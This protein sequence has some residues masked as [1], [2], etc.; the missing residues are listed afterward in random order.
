MI[1]P[2]KG[3]HARRVI[4]AAGNLE[5]TRRYFW[6]KGKTGVFPVDQA[7]GIEQDGPITPGAVQMMVRMGIVG[8]F[9]QGAA[10]L[11]QIGGVTVGREKLRLVV[12]AEGE[13]VRQA[14]VAGVV[15]ASWSE[16]DA[17][18]AEG[19][20]KGKTR[21]YT[22]ADG[23]FVP[24]VTQTEKD[25]RR[26]AQAV[27]RQ[28]RSAAGVGNTREL[29]AARA[30]TREKSREMKLGLFYDQEKRRRHVFVTEKPCE[31]FGPLLKIFAG[32]VG[33]ER[34]DQTISLSDG[35]KWIYGQVCAFLLTL[36]AILLDFYH[37][38]QH[39]HAAATECFGQG[40]A[41]A[42][43]WAK[44]RL[45]EIK[46]LG[47]SAVLAAIEAL[48]KK[49]RAPRK[50]ES[51]RLL[52]EYIASRLDMLDYR[53]A[54]A[55]G[56]DIGS[57]PT[58]AMCKNLTLRMKRPGMKWDAVYAGAMMNLIALYESGQATACHRYRATRQAA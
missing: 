26:K 18:V 43:E 13:A 36:M 5:L 51:L 31:E 24:T 1:L 48:D 9:R 38:S 14:R 35:A 32:Q 30:G 53:T 37:L 47:P 42:A 46:T 25:K 34:A 6:A 41:A 8:D 17:V 56:W 7:L 3:V 57:G 33:F 4:S 15:P 10:D 52:R 49:T 27:R 39:V 11:K 21:I 54:L 20:D 44:A 45:E 28:Q 55:N 40:T 12:E 58:E 22:G 50:K 19:P 29:P 16:K 2:D 23:V